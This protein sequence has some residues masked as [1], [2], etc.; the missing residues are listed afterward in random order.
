MLST[1]SAGLDQ[2][3]PSYKGVAVG[4]SNAKPFLREAL[5]SRF[6]KF[7]RTM[8]DE[9]PESLIRELQI[10]QLWA[11]RNVLAN[12]MNE[13]RINSYAARREVLGRVY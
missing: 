2:M 1:P 6:E 13:E 4:T 5:M 10:E 11:Y 7:E 3:L 8:E 12:R 9:L